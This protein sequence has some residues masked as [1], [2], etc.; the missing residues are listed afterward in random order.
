MFE[1]HSE[2]RK[3][4]CE[5]LSKETDIILQQRRR[6]STQI[7]LAFMFQILKARERERPPTTAVVSDQANSESFN[8]NSY[9]LLVLALSCFQ[10]LE[11]K[12]KADLGATLL[13]YDVGLLPGS[14]C[15]SNLPLS[16]FDLSLFLPYFFHL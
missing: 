6:R 15:F 3:S 14:E 1:K 12:S 13:Q 16:L 8:L 11:H 2:P 10:D 4:E 9:S 7:R 5:Q